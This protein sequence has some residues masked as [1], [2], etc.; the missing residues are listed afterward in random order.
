MSPAAGTVV[1]EPLPGQLSGVYFAP[2]D[3]CMTQRALI[4]G[5]IARGP[6]RLRGTLESAQTVATRRVLAQLGVSFTVDEEDWLVVSRREGNTLQEPRVELDCGESV[7]TMWLMAGL[8]SGFDFA[9]T[10]TGGPQLLACDC[11]VLVEQL[12]QLG[13]RIECLGDGGYGP[14]RVQGH[15]LPPADCKIPQHSCLL[16]DALI[17]ASLST[18]GISR[19]TGAVNGNDHLDRLLRLMGVSIRRS[20]EVLTIKGGQ[21]VHP[22]RITIP[23]DVT[24]AAPLV[25]AAVLQPGSD[26]LIRQSG[27]NPGRMGLFK[28]LSRIGADITRERD[29][30]YGSEPV[31]NLRVRYSPNLGPF[32]VSPNLAPFLLDEFTLLALVATQVNGRS[33]LHNG[34]HWL[35]CTANV[36]QMACDILRQFGADIEQTEDG[37]VVSGPTRLT[38]AAVQCAN[39]LSL[40][41]LALAA[42]FIADGPSTLYAAGILEET[43]PGLLREIRQLGTEIHSG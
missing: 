3:R 2:G 39:N 14:I 9:A 12:E 35:G 30:Q 7:A 34:H 32:N 10:L 18:T 43:Y 6:V 26:V 42:G 17:L 22:R 19:F 20:G 25:V 24:A 41:L 5:S 36:N 37:F 15:H 11:G 28:T 23:G 8:L 31:T 29:W 1:V 38:G 13:A 27:A 40:S 21:N 4:L 33:H 16:K